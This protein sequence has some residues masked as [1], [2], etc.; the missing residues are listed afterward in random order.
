[1]RNIAAR[2]KVEF[3]WLVVGRD[4]GVGVVLGGI[5]CIRRSSSSLFILRHRTSS[6]RSSLLL[7][8][9]LQQRPEITNPLPTPNPL[10]II[11][12]SHLQLERRDNRS[13]KV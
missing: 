7:L 8:I 10:L 1:M 12:H 6:S 2:A 4:V 11:H 13:V 3:G 5:V 9:S